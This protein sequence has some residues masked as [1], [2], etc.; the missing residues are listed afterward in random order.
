M[1][2]LCV[3]IIISELWEGDNGYHLYSKLYIILMLNIFNLI[4]TYWSYTFIARAN[5]D[6]E[7][8]EISVKSS[9]QLN[10]PPHLIIPS[11][12]IKL[13]ETIGQGTII[14]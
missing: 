10:L 8:T 1:I 7:R 11:S 5:S 14:D 13:N 3:V 12:S 2:L 6:E 4:Q 9:F